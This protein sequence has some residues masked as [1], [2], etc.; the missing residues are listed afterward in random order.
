MQAKHGQSRRRRRR[1]RRRRVARYYIYRGVAT[2]ARVLATISWL[3]PRRGKGARRRFNRRERE[4][5]RRS[6]QAAGVSK[7]ESRTRDIEWPNARERR[8]IVGH[9]QSPVSSVSSMT[10]RVAWSASYARFWQRPSV[11][12][13]LHSRLFT[14]LVDNGVDGVHDVDVASREPARGSTVFSRS[15]AV[16]VDRSAPLIPGIRRATIHFNDSTMRL[17]GCHVAVVVVVVVLVPC[18]LFQSP[19]GH[20]GHGRLVYRQLPA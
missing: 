15:A 10:S 20:L 13:Y 9:V 19:E 14:V 8:E 11:A 18:P 6:Y 2:P 7:R 12:T 4:R 17:P 3:E 5:E 1:R 16:T